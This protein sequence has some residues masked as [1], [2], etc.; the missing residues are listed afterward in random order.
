MQDGYARVGPPPPPGRGAAR[1]ARPPKGEHTM[2][3][4][5]PSQPAAR[6]DDPLVQAP[7][8]PVVVRSYGLTDRGRVRESNEDHFLIAELARALWVRQTSL[9]QP[10]AQYGRNRA[11]VF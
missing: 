1:P 9:P 8:P 10:Q 7:P 6:P 11:H 2:T 3:A 4:A 5:N